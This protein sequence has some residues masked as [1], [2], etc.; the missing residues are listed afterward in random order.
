[1]NIIVVFLFYF[2]GFLGG[3][4]GRGGG[5]RVMGALATF[6]SLTALASTPLIRCAICVQTGQGTQWAWWVQWNE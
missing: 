5:A 6:R 3:G 4:R 2:F 1:M